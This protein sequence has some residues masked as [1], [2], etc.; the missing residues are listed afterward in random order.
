MPPK[1][2]GQV[3][4]VDSSNKSIALDKANKGIRVLATGLGLENV[5]GPVYQDPDSIKNSA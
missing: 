2:T 1:K 4:F 5:V 3:V